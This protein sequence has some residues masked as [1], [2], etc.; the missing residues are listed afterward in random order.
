MEIVGADI[1]NA[2]TSVVSGGRVEFFPSFVAQTRRAYQGGPVRH[3]TYQDRHYLIGADALEQPGH[4][5]LMADALTEDEAY[6]R[7]LSAR[8]FVAFLAGLSALFPD[9]E[10]LD[11]SLGT[12]APL[13]FY[14]AFSAHITARYV[15][16]HVYAYQGR[17]RTL[18]VH[19][20]RVFGEGRAALV[21]LTPEQLEGGVSVHD[22]GGRTYNVQNFL[23]GVAKGEGGSYDSGVD[24]MLHD[25]AS[26]PRDPGA[27]W[28]MQ[29]E[30][31]RDPKA[32]GDVRR[33]LM[34]SIDDQLQV[35]EAK[36]RISRAVRHIV[37]GGGAHLAAPVIKARYKKPVIVVGGGAPQSANAVA[38]WLAMGGA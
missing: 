7:Y 24:R 13:G 36:Q 21:L 9:R 30:M 6:K 34:A 38:Y 18:T 17:A 16:P 33:E 11:I 26:V 35:I 3:V 12:G 27:R 31:W 2:T 29:S 23:D 4:D 37:I 15:G 20:G 14:E 5:S 22:I 10:H 19:A 25:I 8:S 28:L 1:G 32:H